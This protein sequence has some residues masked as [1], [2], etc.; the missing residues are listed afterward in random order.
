MRLFADR[1]GYALESATVF[2]RWIKTGQPDRPDAIRVEI[3]LRG[4]LTDDQ[5][6]RT[7][8]VSNACAVQRM[9]ANQTTIE[10]VITST[11]A[12]PFA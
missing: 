8:A 7:Y 11:P 2:A 1:K 12:Q 3:D 5:R 9:L 6:K 10:S 4:D